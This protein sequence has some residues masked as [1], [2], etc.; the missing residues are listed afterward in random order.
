M[1]KYCIVCNNELKTRKAKYF[2]SGKCDQL[3]RWNVIRE[4]IE[5]TGIAEHP[6]SAK[7]YLIE[8]NGSICKEC[9]IFEW[10]GKKLSLILDHIDGDASNCNL[11]NLRLLC[12]NCDSLTPTFKNRNYG[13]GRFSRRQRY[14][15]GKSY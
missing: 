2:C 12:P 8:V 6:R 15:E 10:Y 14:K 7:R 13:K 9:G 4:K 3:K 5:A 1:L 11:I